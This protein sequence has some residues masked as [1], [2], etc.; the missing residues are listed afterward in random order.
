MQSYPLSLTYLQSSLVEF[1]LWYKRMVTVLSSQPPLVNP[2][3]NSS[4]LILNISHTTP[5][6]GTHFHAHKN[7]V[8]TYSYG[9]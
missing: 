6:R 1:P 7:N 4:D 3:E 5:F 2:T 8:Y 9:K